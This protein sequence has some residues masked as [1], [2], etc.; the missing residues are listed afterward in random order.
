MAVALHLFEGYCKSRGLDHPEITAYVDYLWRFIGLS[1]PEAFES[2]EAEQPPL[3]GVGLGDEFPAGVEDHLRVHGV[4]EAE[5]RWVLENTTEVLFG[6]MYGA[7]DDK[8][9]RL[10]LAALADLVA[11]FGVPW[12]DIRRFVASRWTDRGGWGEVLS[13]DELARWRTL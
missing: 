3:V 9:S 10:H 8:G 5:F 2:W 4:P 13:V 7:A 12:P 6:S 1:R 11:P